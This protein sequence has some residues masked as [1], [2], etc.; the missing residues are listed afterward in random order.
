MSNQGEIHD[1]QTCLCEMCRWA[2]RQER[3]QMALDSPALR[4]TRSI[5]HHWE[6][7]EEQKRRETCVE[8]GHQNSV[9]L[10]CRCR[11][12]Q[13]DPGGSMVYCGCHCTFPDTADDQTALRNLHEALQD[14]DHALFTDAWD[15]A[16]SDIRRV[17]EQQCAEFFYELGRRDERRL[18]TETADED[19][20]EMRRVARERIGREGR[21]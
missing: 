9:V 20:G 11:E 3:E 2:D 12:T 21:K 7:V 13:R 18:L 17:T 19:L 15:F 6:I 10:R 16:P 4:R 8:C 14:N 5:V 1:T